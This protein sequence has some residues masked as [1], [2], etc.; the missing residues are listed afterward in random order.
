MGRAIKLHDADVKIQHLY[1]KAVLDKEIQLKVE[2]L[3]EYGLAD[4]LQ[5][6]KLVERVYDS[7]NPLFVKRTN[8]YAAHRAGGE[9]GWA[10]ISRVRVLADLAKLKEMDHSEHMKF[11]VVKDL[12]VKIRE[13]IIKDQ[14]MTLDAM[15]VLVAEA[16]AMDIVNNSLKSDQQKHPPQQGTKGQ[17]RLNDGA[18]D[19]A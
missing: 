1:L 3:P 15:T 6:L 8:F 4:A 19:E 9:V 14:S 7:A 12:P 16:E 11:K 17:G 10:Y 5:V 18:G 13:N 2:A